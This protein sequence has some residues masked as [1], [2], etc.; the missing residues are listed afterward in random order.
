VLKNRNGRRGESGELK[1][2]KKFNSFFEI[3]ED[4]KEVYTDENPFDD[5]EE[6]QVFR[7]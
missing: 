1:F 7:L 4:F 6:Q 2:T 5:D 3:P